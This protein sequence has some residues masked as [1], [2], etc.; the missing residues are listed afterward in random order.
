ME[1]E[2]KPSQR[3][4]SEQDS[5]YSSGAQRSQTDSSFGAQRSCDSKS[6]T[7][8][9]GATRSQGD[10]S[11][12]GGSRSQTRS[13]TSNDGRDGVGGAFPG[14]S[15]PSVV[16]ASHTSTSVPSSIS[17]SHP[18]ATKDCQTSE[19][20]TGSP[21]ASRSTSKEG[22]GK[23][24]SLQG[25]KS[26]T[27]G[28][29]SSKTQ[30]FK[31]KK[32]VDLNRE[33]PI[34]QHP[35]EPEPPKRFD[36]GR[37]C[38]AVSLIDG[39][40][41]QTS[42]SLTKD[43]GFPGDMWIGRNILDFVH[44]DDRSTFTSR[45]TENIHLE[46]VQGEKHTFAVRVRQYNGL[47]KG[48]VVRTSYKPFLLSTFFRGLSSGPQKNES[49]F[50]KYLFIVAEPIHCAF[51]KPLEDRPMSA[52]IGKN[53][54]WTQHKADYALSWLDPAAVSFIGF[55]NQH[56]VGQS[57]FK[58]IHPHDLGM[59]AETFANLCQTRQTCHSKG[60][61]MRIKNGSFITVE[62]TWNT[63]INPWTQ[64]LEFV[65]G[66]HEVVLGPQCLDNFFGGNSKWTGHDSREVMVKAK[67]EL[68]RKG[69]SGRMDLVMDEMLKQT[70]S[71][72]EKLR[73]Q[74]F[75]PHQNF[76]GSSSDSPSYETLNY[77]ASISR[78]LNSK[79]SSQPEE[80]GTGQ[81]Q[82]P[83]ITNELPSDNEPAIMTEGALALHDNEMAAKLKSQY[84]QERK[85]LYKGRHSHQ[86]MEAF[87]KMISGQGREGGDVSTLST[88]IDPIGGGGAP[89]TSQNNLEE[90]DSSDLYT[91]LHT[92]TDISIE[93]SKEGGKRNRDSGWWVRRTE[94][95]WNQRVEITEKLAMQ[96][97]L[98]RADLEETLNND[99]EKLA[100]MD[101][102]Q[103][104]EEQ[105]DQLIKEIGLDGLKLNEFMED[106]RSSP[107]EPELSTES[108]TET[109]EEKNAG[110]E[111]RK[112]VWKENYLVSMSIM[113]EE[114]AP[115]PEP[116]P[117]SLAKEVQ[118]PGEPL[119]MSMGSGSSNASDL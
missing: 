79:P 10:L 104:V 73:H 54:F 64:K 49:Q 110:T 118:M 15:V 56:I 75:I 106:L 34:Q 17:T 25:K 11:G 8:S 95:F 99:L 32:L 26:S 5:A 37:F 42:D 16:S 3:T 39:Q 43:L 90:T 31:K 70:K 13:Q 52:R 60:V 9:S 19:T 24:K 98:P 29:L 66:R 51:T 38:V 2:E 88:R 103:D 91:F 71:L 53:Y 116:T 80:P 23:T 69:E 55:L 47:G 57:I 117:E 48:F 115:I 111:L 40:V 30:P 78:F 74:V 112:M 94:P 107:S 63:F 46:M 93:A 102:P 108:E 114:D 59:I 1:S 44:A 82:M 14:P 97:K 36:E 33:P 92:S 109:S 62:T 61:R 84:N 35:A 96:Y 18:P 83:S 20:R 113:L 58:C 105:L 7:G 4:T 45:I 81:V 21:Q 119:H 6:R 76:F 86:K 85:D 77:R 41:R 101:Q 72:Q 87:C 67:R 68:K 100:K 65:M 27:T 50:G 28:R 12:R 89:Q 22:G